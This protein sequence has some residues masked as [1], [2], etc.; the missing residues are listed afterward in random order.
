[1]FYIDHLFDDMTPTESSSIVYSRHKKIGFTV[2]LIL[3]KVEAKCDRS[4]DP[5][6][7]AREMYVK[8][9]MV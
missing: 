3:I 8:Y 2:Y 4:F 7:D 5:N 9:V 1:M 6:F